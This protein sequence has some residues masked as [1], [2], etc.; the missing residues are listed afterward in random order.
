MELSKNVKQAMNEEK[1]ALLTRDP[2]NVSGHQ[3]LREKY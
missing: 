3:I 2:E 1:F